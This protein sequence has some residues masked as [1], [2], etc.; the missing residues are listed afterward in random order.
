M[1][2][3]T[4]SR[5]KWT[6]KKLEEAYLKM[7]LT[8]G[9]RPSSVFAFTD[10]IGISEDK[11]YTFFNSFDAVENAIFTGLMEKTIK[12]VKN[13]DGYDTFAAQEKLLTFYFA[14][15]EILKSHRSFVAL[16]WPE[17]KRNPGKTPSWL[18]GYRKAFLDFARQIVMEGITNE[19]IKERPFISDRYDKAFW[20]QL[21]FVVH[22]WINDDSSDFEKTDAAIEKAVNLSF[23][24]LGDTTI[25]SF[26]D[27]AKFLWQS[28]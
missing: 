9:E 16:K 13:G 26:I 24:L 18:K 17:I 28:K 7:L 11:F 19:E 23:Q 4:K 3:K 25:D 8:K 20:V 10:S 6:S 15:I 5:P 21:A 12:T 2:T 1:A 27:F 22:F 14:H